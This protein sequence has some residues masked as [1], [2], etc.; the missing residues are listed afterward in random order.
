M[1]SDEVR[2]IENRKMHLQR[3]QDGYMAM[4]E[5]ISAALKEDLGYN[6]FMSEFGAH[7]TVQG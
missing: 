5:E 1:Y 6:D 4:K 2:N 3:L 7:V